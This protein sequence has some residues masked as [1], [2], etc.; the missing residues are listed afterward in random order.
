[1]RVAV[2]PDAADGVEREAWEALLRLLGGRAQFFVSKDR[3]GRDARALDDRPSAYLPGDALNQIALDV[4]KRQ[5]EN[6]G[7]PR[8]DP[9]TAR[10]S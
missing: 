9:E 3:I 1:M 8:S 10:E 6:R 5:S 2:C 4:Y 7:R